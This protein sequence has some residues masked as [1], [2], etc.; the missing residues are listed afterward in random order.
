MDIMEHSKLVY[1]VANKYFRTDKDKEDLIQEGFIGLLKASKSWNEKNAAFSTFAM[2]CILNEMLMFCRKRK[3]QNC[4]IKLSDTEYPEFEDT[5]CKIDVLDR[6]FGEY[7]GIVEML[8]KGYKQS[9]I[10]KMMGVSRQLINVRIKKVR[11]M[12]KG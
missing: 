2:K 8:E 10:A 12:V 4:E 9:E 6:D 5:R 7:T 1:S 11:E 3:K